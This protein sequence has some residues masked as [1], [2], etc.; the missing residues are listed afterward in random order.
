MGELHERVPMTEEDLARWR[1]DNGWKLRWY[2]EREP[3]T[4]KSVP[5]GFS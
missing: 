4:M 2:P 3:P 1:R 5:N